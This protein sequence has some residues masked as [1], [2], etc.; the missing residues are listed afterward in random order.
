MERA[1]AG[2]IGGAGSTLGTTF[3]CA[4]GAGFADCLSASE[5]SDAAAGV[6]EGCCAIS[7]WRPTPARRRMA[8]GEEL[9]LDVQ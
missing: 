1:S 3:R 7:G 5:A 9:L 8:R 4:G 6:P 2:G